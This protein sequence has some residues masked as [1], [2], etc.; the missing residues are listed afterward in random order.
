VQ[1][2]GIVPTSINFPESPPQS[3]SEFQSE[4]SSDLL[5]KLLQIPIVDSPGRVPVY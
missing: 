5:E 1:Q 2:S 4:E 3:Q